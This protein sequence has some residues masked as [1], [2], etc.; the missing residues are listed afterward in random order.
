MRGARPTKAIE[1][2]QRCAE[3]MGYHWIK[4]TDPIWQFDAFMFRQA[5]IAA[6]K[7]KK[8]RHAIDENVF[9]EKLFPEEV[10]AL[11]SLPLPLHVLRELW[12]RTQ[13][14]RAW[15]RFS[16]LP[17]TTAEIE[18]NT[19]ENYRNTHFDEE[20]WRNAPFRINI[21][22]LPKKRDEVR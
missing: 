3:K 5:V 16:L 7:I 10:E 20:K 1:E 9:V 6:I 8:I 15:R 18:F 19:A 11:R 17:D 22:L 4:N 21:P 2:A 14:E 13:N 12:I